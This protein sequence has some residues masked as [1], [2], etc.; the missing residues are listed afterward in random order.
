VIWKQKSGG[1]AKEENSY[2][3]KKIWGQKSEERRWF[4]PAV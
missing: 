3:E 1:I 2:P 4:I